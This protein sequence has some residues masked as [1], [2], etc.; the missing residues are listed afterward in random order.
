MI[1]SCSELPPQAALR[2]AI[3]RT[4]IE[5]IVKYNRPKDENA[6]FRTVVLLEFTNNGADDTMSDGE[7]NDLCNPMK[8]P[9]A[10]ASSLFSSGHSWFLRI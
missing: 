6:Y 2:W 8:D 10:R 1:V 4:L 5:A 9:F 7:G 3:A